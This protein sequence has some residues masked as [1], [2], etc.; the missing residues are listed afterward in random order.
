MRRLKRI[1][2]MLL[3][4]GLVTTCFT[5]CKSSE[6]KDINENMIYKEQE[7][8]NECEQGTITDCFA[9]NQNNIFT[10]T[11][12][13]GKYLIQSL[14]GNNVVTDWINSAIDDKTDKVTVF[15]GQNG[16][17]YAI[18]KSYHED[19]YTR[20][21]KAS[22]DNTSYEDVTPAF[23]KEKIKIDESQ[24]SYPLIEKVLVDKN[25]DIAFSQVGSR[26]LNLCKNGNCSVINTNVSDFCIKDNIIYYISKNILEYN[27]ESDKN[28][29][30]LETDLNLEFSYILTQG[31]SIYILNDNGIYRKAIDGSII[32]LILDS[33]GK[34]MKLNDMSPQNFFITSDNSLIVNYLKLST[35]KPVIY[36]YSL[37]EDSFIGEKKK[38]TIFSMSKVS[39][40]DETISTFNELY[41]DVEIEYTCDADNQSSAT[42]TERISAF[43]SEVLSGN[44][45][46]VIFLD[47]MPEESYIEKGVL[48]DMSDIFKP[49]IDNKTILT[50]I[51]D[52]YITD[53]NKIYCMPCLF[54]V[55]VVWEDNQ[56]NNISI[57]PHSL[58]LESEK[59][60]NDEKKLLPTF[61]DDSNNNIYKFLFNLFM[62]TSYNSLTDENG[63]IDQQAYLQYIEDI[64]TIAD[65]CKGGSEFK[66]DYEDALNQVY[67]PDFWLGGTEE[68]IGDYSYMALRPSRAVFDMQSVMNFGSQYNFNYQTINNY[69][70]PTS[71][72]SIN[73]DTKVTEEA[74]AFVELLL[75][76]DIQDVTRF[77]GLPMNVESFKKDLLC[78]QDPFQHLSTDPTYNPTVA[79]GFT[80]RQGED[81]Y[82]ES[83]WSK[84]EER[85][86]LYNKFITVNKP[87]F[88]DTT[89]FELLY[90]K[91]SDYFEGK[92]S[93]EQATENAL[94]AANMYLN[95]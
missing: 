5:S 41:P 57:N 36:K 39:I 78:E 86:K 75:S 4:M 87:I 72:V 45:A 49:M 34:K 35:N 19:C 84:Q 89:M 91:T 9:D 27:C 50:N 51:A 58:A 82:L 95:E 69:Y 13:E 15:T 3:V 43:N 54:G 20:L 17:T 44:G 25:G 73:S 1:I 62:Y 11:K 24:E 26:N 23:F 77:D 30:N 55:P 42:Y 52:N 2:S 64:K 85:Q 83:T 29:I 88:T 21:I 16:N 65:N 22:H 53:D 46:D 61:S 80:T 81:I 59:Y 66:F 94:S 71:V 33:Q 14:D 56:L 18:L 48:L 10:V 60:K 68:I 67:Y 37:S 76:K 6:S 79:I 90:S 31:S 38:L 8:S 12:N 32:E 47:R 93:A 74:K 92:I 28:S 70:I 63:N 40:L 7:I